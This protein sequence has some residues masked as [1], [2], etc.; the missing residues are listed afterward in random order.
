MDAMARARAI[1]KEHWGYERFRPLQH[2]VVCSSLAGRDC[3]ALLP[4]G[5]GKSVCFQVPAIASSGLTVVVSP[6][7]SLMQNQVSDLV[8]RGVCAGSLSSSQSREENRRT[9]TAALSGEMK[10]LY[11]SPERLQVTCHDLAA[12]RISILAVDEAHCI[13]EWGHEFRPPYRLLS[14][15]RTVLGEPQVIAL[16]ATATPQTR[17]DV[18]EVLGLRKP[19]NVVGSFDR[20]NLRFHAREAR[21][22][23]ERLKALRIALRSCSGTAVVYVP[24]RGRVDDVT[25]ILRK[26]SVDAWPYHAAM[27][28]ED[29]DRVLSQ[30][31]D[32]TARVVVATNAFGMGIDRPD[33]R[34]V[35]HLGVPARPEAYYQEAGRAGRDGGAGLCLLLWTARD[36]ELTRFLSGWD[37][38]GLA[39]DVA[40]T[41]K[42]ALKAMV[43]YVKKRG[44][45]RARLLG[46]LGEKLETCAGCDFC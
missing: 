15:C 38:P 33:V 29:R 28:M 13:S 8:A 45:R 26:W 9:L 19:V 35:A 36:L 23:A 17:V 11:L 42:Q 37:R 21:T 20:P 31:L 44:C 25:N 6:L 39:T 32:G 12:C 18:S 5:G 3:L 16:T 10:V 24:T 41:R 27:R 7:I 34:L 46:Y 40:R 43:D 2:R 14:R 4:T 22:E 1:L 30:F